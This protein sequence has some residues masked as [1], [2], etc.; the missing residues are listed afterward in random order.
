MF[1]CDLGHTLA[2]ILLFKN[3]YNG[4]GHPAMNRM[5]LA[6]SLLQQV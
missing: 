2:A 1:T 4:T 5:G 6:G 3:R